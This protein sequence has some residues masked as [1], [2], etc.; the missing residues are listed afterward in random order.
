LQELC[1]IIKTLLVW[2]ETIQI[3][4]ADVDGVVRKDGWCAGNYKDTPMKL[5]IRISVAAQIDHLILK[6]GVFVLYEHHGK[7]IPP[8]ELSFWW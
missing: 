7:G 3:K 1:Q 6:N 4:R 2:K 5:T 8:S